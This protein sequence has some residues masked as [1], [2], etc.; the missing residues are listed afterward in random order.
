MAMRGLIGEALGGAPICKDTER[1]LLGADL[2]VHKA[3]KDIARLDVA[4]DDV[5]LVNVSERQR[6]MVTA[7]ARKMQSRV[8]TTGFL[9]ADELSQAAVVRIE[10]EHMV[11]GTPRNGHEKELDDARGVRAIAKGEHDLDLTRG[12]PRGICVAWGHL[13]RHSADGLES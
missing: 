8:V 10:H 11:E 7:V 9:R 4:M 1:P 5:A 6:E 13:E 2:V 3:A 12:Q